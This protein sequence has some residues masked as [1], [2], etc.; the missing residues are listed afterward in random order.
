[1]EKGK[2]VL[3]TRDAVTIFVKKGVEVE[4][5]RDANTRRNDL[6]IRKVA[7]VALTNEDKCIVLDE[8]P[9]A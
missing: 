9:E 1:M 5:E 7:L 2:V 3:A 6:Y 4:N 8:N